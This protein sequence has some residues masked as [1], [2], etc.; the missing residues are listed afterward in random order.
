MPFF[1]PSREGGKLSLLFQASFILKRI[2][3]S[4]FF[5]FLPAGVQ[6]LGLVSWRPYGDKKKKSN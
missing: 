3:P 5:L 2:A 6:Y 4:C 1:M